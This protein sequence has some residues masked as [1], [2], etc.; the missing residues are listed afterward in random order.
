MQVLA[1]AFSLAF[2]KA[3]RSIDAK[4]AMMAITTVTTTSTSY[5]SCWL[6]DK[7]TKIKRFL[8]VFLPQKKTRLKLSNLIHFRN[9]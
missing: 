9:C 5:S 3:G 8:V 6:L 4:I 2:C 1:L 7:T